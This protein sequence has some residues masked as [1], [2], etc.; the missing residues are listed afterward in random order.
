MKANI[1]GRK[2]ILE[3]LQKRKTRDVEK[4]LVT[5]FQFKEFEMLCKH[6]HI[7]AVTYVNAMQTNKNAVQDGSFF[8]CSLSEKN[9]N[10]ADPSLQ[11]VY[12]AEQKA[13]V[14]G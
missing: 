11:L 5:F 10:M 9:E 3:M 6:S 4:S 1:Q 2:E 8:R 14:D 7:T 12:T 13:C